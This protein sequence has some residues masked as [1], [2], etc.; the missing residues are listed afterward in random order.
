MFNLNAK[1]HGDLL[2]GTNVATVRDIDLCGYV[3]LVKAP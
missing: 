1:S 2:P 3:F